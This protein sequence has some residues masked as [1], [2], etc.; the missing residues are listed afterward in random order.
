MTSKPKEWPGKAAAVVQSQELR[1]WRKWGKQRLRAA[2]A[3]GGL[4][5]FWAAAYA[6][7]PVVA[8]SQIEKI[9]SSKLGRAVTVGAVNFKP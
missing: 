2:W 5:L 9:A 7:V 4:L 8:K 1:K 6:L 3:L